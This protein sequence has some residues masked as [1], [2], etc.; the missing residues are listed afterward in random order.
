MV[1][2]FGNDLDQIN[3]EVLGLKDSKKIVFDGDFSSIF[4]EINQSSLFGQP[5]NIIITDADFLLDK[6]E[7]ASELIDTLNKNDSEVFCLVKNDKLDKFNPIVKKLKIKLIKKNKITDFNKFDEIKKICL[8]ENINFDSQKT[9]E[10]FVDHLANNYLFVKS[11]IE[12]IKIYCGDRKVTEKDIE[13]IMLDNFEGNIFLL[14]T[15]ILRNQ[16]KESL[17]L[18]NKLISLKH[19][20][21]EIIQIIS[22]QIFKVKLYKEALNQNLPFTQINS[23][24]QITPFQA[25]QM[26][27]VKDI[28]LGKINFIL[29]KLF[30]LDTNIKMGLVDPNQSFKF[31]LAF[32]NL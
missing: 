27:Y 8:E 25:R 32:I 21:V 4:D 9:F 29:D 1:I 30:E 13:E 16:L 31:F 26:A 2:Y 17:N 7:E 20:P 28:S 5:K 6:S 3:D 23:N 15:Y 18:Y 14:N 22:S 11:E 10:K 24:L 19:Q 12:K